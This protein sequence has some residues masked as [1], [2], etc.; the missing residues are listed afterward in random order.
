MYG[1]LERFCAAISLVTIKAE[2]KSNSRRR[3]SAKFKSK[4]PAKFT[5][6]L[7]NNR[8]V[9]GGTLGET[10]S[11]R[12]TKQVLPQVTLL[13]LLLLRYIQMYVHICYAPVLSVFL[14]YLIAEITHYIISIVVQS[15]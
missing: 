13:L 10:T 3:R 14:F 4:E 8:L 9:D 6:L 12:W 2:G 5:L 7:H 1:V 15:H 11:E